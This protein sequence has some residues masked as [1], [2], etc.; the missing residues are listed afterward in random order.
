MLLQDG[1]GVTKKCSS[2][3]CQQLR[4]DITQ[5][6]CCVVCDRWFHIICLDLTAEAVNHMEDFKCP[7]CLVG[8]ITNSKQSCP[9]C[10]KNIS[11]LA[12][13]TFR[14]QGPINTRCPSSGHS[15]TTSI[16]KLVKPQD[17]RLLDLV[18]NSRCKVLKLV[19]NATRTSFAHHPP[20]PY[21]RCHS[22]PNEHQ[23]LVTCTSLRSSLLE[24][25]S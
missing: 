25:A 9:S 20:H 3:S 2:S 12:N 7:D 19:P 18:K 22:Q 23:F 10:G 21:Q 16:P 24:S 15:T 4:G 5:W 11:L 6:I 17:T 14:E 1:L 13:N 8:R